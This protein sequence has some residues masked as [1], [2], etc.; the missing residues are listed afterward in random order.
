MS[1]R[2]TG[3]HALRLLGS[4]LFDKYPRLTLILGH[5]GEALPFNLHRM[6]Q[7]IAWSPMGYPISS[8]TSTS[9]PRETSAPRV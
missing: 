3:L 7:R 2:T 8:T 5:L 1:T 9:R 6:D 4:G